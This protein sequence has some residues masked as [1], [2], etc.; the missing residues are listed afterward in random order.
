MKNREAV[1]L[2]RVRLHGLDLS[3]KHVEDDPREPEIEK[4]AVKRAISMRVIAMSVMTENTLA[5]SGAD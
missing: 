4:P 5:G 2:K 1:C 3:T